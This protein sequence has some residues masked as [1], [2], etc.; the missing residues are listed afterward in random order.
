[1][2]SSKL[3]LQKRGMASEDDIIKY[4]VLDNA[5]LFKNINSNNAIARTCAIRIL[6]Q[7]YT[8]DSTKF[9]DALLKRL[10]IEKALYTKI[11]ICNSLENGN[12]NTAKLMIEYLGNIGNNQYKVVPDKVSQK[13]SY[14]LPRDII[15]RTLGKMN[16]QILNNMWIVLENNNQNQISEILDAIGFMIFYNNQ[17]ATLDNLIKIKKVIDKYSNNELIIWKCA[18]C[19]SAFPIK[20]SIDM[21]EEI[22]VINKNRTIILECERSLKLIKNR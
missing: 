18:L 22:K 11:E 10:S 19:L 21:L 17:F 7:R 16:P 6:V 4:S 20:E 3:D 12:E 9:V 1:M 5:E 14:P 2:K 8:I 15:A 13:I